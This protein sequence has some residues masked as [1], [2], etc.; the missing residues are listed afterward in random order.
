MADMND[1]RK[2]LTSDDPYVRCHGVSQLVQLDTPEAVDELVPMLGDPNQRVRYTVLKRLPSMKGFDRWSQLFPLLEDEDGSI[3]IQAA[4]AL[5]RADVVESLPRLCKALALEL[6]PKTQ[7]SLVQAI[8]Q[9]G[10]LDTV[11]ALLPQLDSTEDRVRANAVE[12][13]SAILLRERAR[14]LERFLDDPNNRVRGNAVVA[15]HLVLPERA[16]ESIRTMLAMED[17]W[18]RLSAIW[19]AGQ[20]ATPDC[21]R[22]VYPM[23][24][25]PDP[26]AKLLTIKILTRLR[27]PGLP[28]LLEPA[29]TD[30][31]PTVVYYAQRAMEEYTRGEA[32]Q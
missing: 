1:I 10:T 32:A 7:A 29:L 28:K 22:L 25:D 31:D 9:M 16:M 2:Q 17:K 5:A 11:K 8:G 24:T 14:L 19:A 26:D 3:R 13:I 4:F 30:A 21:L 12:S 18:F 20:I 27:P 23:V 15:L 6:D